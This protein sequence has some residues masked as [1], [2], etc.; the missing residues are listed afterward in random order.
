MYTRPIGDWDMKGVGAQKGFE[1]R[2]YHTLGAHVCVCVCLEKKHDTHT[3]GQR[4]W[5]LVRKREKRKK[6]KERYINV[7]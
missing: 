2:T 1:P 5:S 6:K 3:Q 4:V 7:F